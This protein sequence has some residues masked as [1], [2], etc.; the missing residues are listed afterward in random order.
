MPADAPALGSVT[1]P[2]CRGSRRDPFADGLDCLECGGIGEVPA[3]PPPAP[4][5]RQAVEDAYNEA[6][7]HA[8]RLCEQSRD[9]GERGNHVEAA[10][11]QT[12]ALGIRTA[13]AYIRDAVKGADE[14][15]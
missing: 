10:R 6:E 12:I 13:L 7:D 2:V 8:K 3:D 15:H 11:R 5:L 1:C 4:T 9:L 14:C